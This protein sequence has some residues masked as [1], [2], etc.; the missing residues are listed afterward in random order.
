MGVAPFLENPSHDREDISERWLLDESSYKRQ[1][2]VVFQKACSRAHKKFSLK[3]ID[4]V[5]CAT[6]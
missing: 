2:G 6:F 1:V 3:L 5:Q 4:V